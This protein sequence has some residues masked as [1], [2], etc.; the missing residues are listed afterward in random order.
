MQA[1]WDCGVRYFDTSPWYGL[2]LSERR[3]GH[4]L[5]T[6]ARDD[7]VLST[8]VGR[9][10]SAAPKPPATMWHDPSPFAYRYDYTAEGVRRSVEDSLQRLG[11]SRIDI[12]Y[13]HDLS[14]E[15]RDMGDHW[16]TY[17][18]QATKGAIPELTR[19]REEGTIK[20]WG[21]GINTPQAALRTLE[22]GDPDIVLL[23]TQ[24]S[25]LHHDEA[26]E[27]TLPALARRGVSVVVGAPLNAGYAAGRDRYDYQ[28]TIPPGMARKRERMS[29]IAQRH[30]V[31]LRTAALQF[32]TANPTVAAVIPGARNAAQVQANARSMEVAIPAAFWSELKQKKL[33]AQAAPI[34]SQI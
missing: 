11:L 21:L 10:L 9:L 15:N 3:F 2:G 30:G 26:L 22:I 20:A 8:K 1:A 29:V 25:I 6:R 34:P 19:M 32:A 28:G 24:Y 7:F 4:F 23:A 14:P 5:H 12:V 27:Q 18:D 16:T 31:D 17:F 13:I 33:I